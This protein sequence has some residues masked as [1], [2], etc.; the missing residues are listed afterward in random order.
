MLD[1]R[2]ANDR[3]EGHL[4]KRIA[5]RQLFG[6]G[7]Q[8]LGKRRSDLAVHQN[9]ASRHADL[10]LMEPG[11]ECDGRSRRV[12]FSIVKYNDRVLAAQLK[13]DFFQMFASE[14]ADAPTDFA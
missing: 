11:A 4:P 10:A 14:F 8:F 12:E 13:L 1:L 3:A 6:L 5:D 9:A 2:A 7:H